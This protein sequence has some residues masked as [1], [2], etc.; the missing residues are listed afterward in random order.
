M[1]SYSNNLFLNNMTITIMETTQFGGMSEG[2]AKWQTDDRADMILMDSN[3]SVRFV[4]NQQ[5]STQ[6]GW[7]GFIVIS[8]EYNIMAPCV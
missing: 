5:G 8:V 4:F 7:E 1:T 3:D 6:R 2:V